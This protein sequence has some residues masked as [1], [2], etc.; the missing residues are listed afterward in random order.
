M[1]GIQK[2]ERE[3]ESHGSEPTM[4][5]MTLKSRTESRSLRIRIPD[6]RTFNEVSG[7]EIRII[8]RNE[9]EGNCL[10]FG[11]YRLEWWLAGR[12]YISLELDAVEVLGEAPLNESRA[13]KRT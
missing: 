13:R 2:S 9:A 10:E 6:I 8:D 11:R 5:R 7:D 12:H 1:Q 4:L 3:P